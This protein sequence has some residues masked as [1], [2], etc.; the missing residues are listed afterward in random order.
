MDSEEKVEQIFDEWF[1]GEI[2]IPNYAPC[3]ALDRIGEWAS[4]L[5]FKA[6]WNAAMKEKEGEKR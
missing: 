3:W 1:K 2:A 4:Y 5:S 6:G